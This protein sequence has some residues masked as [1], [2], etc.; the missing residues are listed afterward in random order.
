MK[1]KPRFIQKDC[2]EG[3]R[4]GFFCFCYNYIDI[5]KFIK[6]ISVLILDL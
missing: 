1:I 2:T 4:V 6:V 3:N 5:T